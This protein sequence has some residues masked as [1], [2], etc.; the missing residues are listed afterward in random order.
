[1]AGSNEP[2][3]PRVSGGRSTAPSY[4]HSRRE[5]TEGGTG[6]QIPSLLDLLFSEP[7]TYPSTLDR[8][9]PS[10]VEGRWSPSLAHLCRKIA[11]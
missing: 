8:R 7:L 10:Y 4:G 11:G 1:M 2:A 3:A 9:S 6:R 5:M